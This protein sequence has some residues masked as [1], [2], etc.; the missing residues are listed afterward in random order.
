MA[1]ERALSTHVAIT[2]RP[3]D[4]LVGAR[5]AEAAVGARPRVGDRRAA[6][7]AAAVG[8][9]GR[10][11]Q[12]E[13]ANVLGHGPAAGGARANPPLVEEAERVVPGGVHLGG[14][15]VGAR[16]AREGG[17]GGGQQGGDRHGEGTHRASPYWWKGGPT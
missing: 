11:T 16:R 6:D 15:A 8:G 4:Q 13:R 3:P 9:G 2:A 1:A 17:G 12:A 10:P 5:E 14:H 7:L